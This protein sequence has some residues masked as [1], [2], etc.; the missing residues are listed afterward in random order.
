[1]LRQLKRMQCELAKLAKEMEE[2][3]KHGPEIKSELEIVG[4]QALL[5]VQ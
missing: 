3:N 1:M 2:K 4:E 5:K